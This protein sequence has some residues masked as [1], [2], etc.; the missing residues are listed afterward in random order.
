MFDTAAAYNNESILGD[1]LADKFKEGKYNRGDVFITTK[2]S[3]GKKKL[4][5]PQKI[6]K[7][8]NFWLLYRF[9]LTFDKFLLQWQE[10]TGQT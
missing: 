4:K 6:S 1:F 5:F 7:F 8:Q 2:V 9:L 3:S 10:K